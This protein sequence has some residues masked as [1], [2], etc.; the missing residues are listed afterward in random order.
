MASISL[1]IVLFL[2]RNT[3]R[4]KLAI[5]LVACGIL[6]L[7]GVVVFGVGWAM[8]YLNETLV[9]RIEEAWCVLLAIGLEISQE[10]YSFCMQ[11]DVRRDLR[12]HV[13]AAKVVVTHR[14]L[15]LSH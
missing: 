5:A 4:K 1:T 12:E 8:I 6:V 13:H 15:F 2:Y 11:C 7:V 14:A 9:Q 10:A 3:D